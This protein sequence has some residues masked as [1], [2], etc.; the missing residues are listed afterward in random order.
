MTCCDEIA[1]PT[2]G[3]NLPAAAAAAESDGSCRS[4]RSCRRW[5]WISDLA[6]DSAATD[7]SANRSRS[8][9]PLDWLD[10]RM[11]T[12]SAHI[13]PTRRP[14]SCMLSLHQHSKLQTAYR[15]ETQ[16]NATF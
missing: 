8:V 3:C 16:R 10:T 11:T 6:V 14:Q 4:G 2:A 1:R 13:H 9:N 5:D 15:A 12:S 7:T